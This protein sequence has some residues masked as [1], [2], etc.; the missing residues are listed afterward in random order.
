[1]CSL[2][3]DDVSPGP[4]EGWSTMSLSRRDVR[5]VGRIDREVR[6]REVEVR[7]IKRWNYA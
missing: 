4:D 6:R 5:D 3:K 1:V 2:L 7:C